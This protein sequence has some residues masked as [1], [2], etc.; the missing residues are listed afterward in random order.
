MKA[1]ERAAPMRSNSSLQ[2]ALA[3]LSRMV[4]MLLGT[5]V[6]APCC[7]A[8][9]ARTKRG[10]NIP[11]TKNILLIAMAAFLI[12]CDDDDSFPDLVIPSSSVSDGVV[13]MAVYAQ[14]DDGVT[15][16]TV[17]LHRHHGR[18]YSQYLSLSDG[19]RLNVGYG[20]W[21][22]D[23][24]VE[25][26]PTEDDPLLAFYKET[27]DIS[28]PGE[29]FALQ[30]LRDETVLL[31]GVGT[32]LDETEFSFT[33]DAEPASMDSVLT[34][35]WVALDGYGYRVNIRFQCDTADGEQVGF[36]LSYP[37][38]GAEALE[39]PVTVDM[40]EFEA[41]PEG[42]VNC[43]ASAKL[44]ADMDQTPEETEADDEPVNIFVARTQELS[45]PLVVD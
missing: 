1:G 39:S 6:T 24:E 12:G 2:F 9:R 16:A 45:L 29:Q 21:N 15:E 35:S 25:L 22:A 44:I 11:M 42:A 17:Y 36:A 43:V 19:D 37:E 41:P 28:Q 30:F 31:S 13:H 3:V 20:D 32:L 8:F 14:T 7:A 34:A 27:L 33:S 40:S 5:L 4:A 23:L 18:G 10:V 26:A 38:R